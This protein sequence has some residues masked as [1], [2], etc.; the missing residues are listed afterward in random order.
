MLTVRVSEDIGNPDFVELYESSFTAEEKIPL[1]NLARTFGNGGNLDFYYDSDVFVG[2]TFC[3]EHD[4][5]TFFVYFA[6]C[7]ACRNKGFGSKILEIMKNQY[8]D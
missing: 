4:K 1:K 7:P 2:F 5:I 3:F 8:A 6:T